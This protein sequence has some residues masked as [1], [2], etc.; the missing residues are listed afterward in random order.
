MKK[1]I[2]R[3]VW[4]IS[5]FLSFRCWRVLFFTTQR[6]T[7]NL[8]F[9][10]SQ[11]KIISSSQPRCSNLDFLQHISLFC[12]SSR[13]ALEP[14]FFL[15]LV[16]CPGCWGRECQHGKIY[17]W[18]L[19]DLSSLRICILD[20][21]YLCICQGLRDSWR[22]S[23]PGRRRIV[24]SW[25]MSIP[26]GIY[27]LLLI[28]M[29]ALFAIVLCLLFSLFR[30]SRLLTLRRWTFISSGEEPRWWEIL[31]LC[32]LMS[33][34]GGS[35]LLTSRRKSGGWSRNVLLGMVLILF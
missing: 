18:S 13:L 32:Q 31:C 16:S 27:L 22:K 15:L 28:L 12:F 21:I 26:L 25:C 9:F 17:L 4:K 11:W 23:M 3:L 34:S 10:L 8:F 14:L 1:I 33:R 30:N 5:G 20:T 19:L 24:R 2:M 35:G 7:R 6:Q 29:L